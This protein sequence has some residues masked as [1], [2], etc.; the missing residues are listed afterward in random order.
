MNFLFRPIF[1]NAIKMKSVWLYWVL[2]LMPFL[3]VIAMSINSNF[4]QISGETGTLSGLE[5]FSMIFGILH[6][7]LFPTIVLAFIASKLFYD[8]LNSGIIFMYKD[9]NRNNILISKWTSLFFI[10]FIFLF[11]LFVSSIIVYFTFLDSYA[12]SSGDLMPISKYMAATIVPS[13]TLYFIEVLTINFVIL[14]S[15]H[16]STGFTIFGVIL[17]LLFTTIAPQLQKAKYILPTGYDEQI[18]SM[19]GGN[20]LIISFVIFLIYFTLTFIYILYKHK[21]IE[22]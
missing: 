17:F 7:M 14:F 1:L 21:K 16:F 13:L 5:F 19:G 15:L 20:V 22:Y 4:L 3:V 10:Q 12:F 6:N 8:E 18:N 11:I 9:I 2:G